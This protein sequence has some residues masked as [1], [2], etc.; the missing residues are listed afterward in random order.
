L[1]YHRSKKRLSCHYCGFGR[2]LPEK[3]PEC[4]EAAIERMGLGTEQVEQVL[5]DRFPAARV[6]RL[7]RDTASGRGLRTILRR[8]GRHEVDLLVGTQMVT[9]GHD[10]PDV[11][12][13]GIIAADLGL[14]FPDFRAA[15][16]TFQLLMQVAGRA[17]RGSRP[18]RVLVQTYSPDHP[19]I[20]YARAH[21]YD[22]FYAH[23]IEDRRELCYPPAGYLAALRVDS[24]DAS[25]VA[26]AANRLAR[27]GRRLISATAERGGAPGAAPGA[28][29]EE[30]F[31][32]GPTEAPIQRLKGRTR[33]LIL[34]KSG[35]RRQLRQVLASL[36][37]AWR[38]SRVD[39]GRQ[40]R[41]SV[42]VDPLM[43]L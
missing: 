8:F 21:D 32:L 5:A 13:V 42:D 38:A 40:V 31:L 18:G 14:N 30:V 27:A 12:L 16:R 2:P 34:L 9:K 28:A 10:F 1:T 3:C 24:A 15:E 35:S 19:S 7:D 25:A 6:A 4:G 22:G 17:G 11:T 37:A 33:W 26:T 43:M 23:E 36:L 20:R 41:V 39:G 29:D